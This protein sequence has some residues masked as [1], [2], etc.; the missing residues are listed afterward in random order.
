MFGDGGFKQQPNRFVPRSISVEEEE[1]KKT[2]QTRTEKLRF[3]RANI[4]TKRDESRN[5]EARDQKE[6]EEVLKLNQIIKEL[7]EENFN[8]REQVD[9]LEKLLA[10]SGDSTNLMKPK[11]IEA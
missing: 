11:G 4:E 3:P 8:L 5:E 7:R 1:T 6:S 9:N 2:E 10:S